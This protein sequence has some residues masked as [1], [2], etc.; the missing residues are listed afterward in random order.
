M[1]VKANLI[2]SFAAGILLSATICGIVYFSTNDKET[3]RVKVEVPTKEEMKSTL[4]EDGYVI[5]TE[6]EWSEQIASAKK[7]AEANIKKQ[8]NSKTTGD[9]KVVYRMVVHVSKGM[10]SIDVGKALA[11][12]GIIKNA[13]TFYKT[14]EKRGLESKLKPGVY[15]VDSSMSLN[16]IIKVIFK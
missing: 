7:E 4:S 3:E 11:Q 13:R 12:G 1:K 16:E 5:L 9:A 2:N 8:T 10:T 14:V 15:K 6:K